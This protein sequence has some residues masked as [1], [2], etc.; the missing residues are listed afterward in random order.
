M[1]NSNRSEAELRR[2][3]DKHS[4][5][6]ELINIEELQTCF[7]EIKYEANLEEIRAC[8]KEVDSDGSGELSFDEFK[9]LFSEV[10]LRKTFD[11]IDADNSGSLTS[12][13]LKR[14]F[15]KLD[16]HMS[17]SLLES[18]VAKVDLDKSGQISY[19]EFREI[20]GKVPNASLARI[21]KVWMAMSGMDL[22]TDLAP[23][24]PPKDLPLIQFLIAGGSGGCLSRTVTAPLER[25]RMQAQV[26]GKSGANFMI[27]YLQQILRE[28]GVK[29]KRSLIYH[30]CSYDDNHTNTSLHLSSFYLSDC[31][32]T[33]STTRPVCWE[34]Y[35]LYARLSLCWPILC[36]L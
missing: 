4:G 32:I 28:E 10:R 17:D 24:V 13:E 15:A 18:M 31:L 35:E 20:F 23:P 3:F 29:G 22:G 2:T 25:V 36:L 5:S 21:S 19:E 26:N 30:Y 12:L 14:A 9:L 27:K 11:D 33:P 8:L 16:I 1:S 34:L 6:D 7:Q